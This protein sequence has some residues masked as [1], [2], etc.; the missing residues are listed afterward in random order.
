MADSDD[1]QLYIQSPPSLSVGLCSH[2]NHRDVKYML[3]QLTLD[4]P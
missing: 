4:G 2:I 1:C 3:S